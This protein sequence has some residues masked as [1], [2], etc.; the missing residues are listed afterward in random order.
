[1]FVCCLG[2]MAGLYFAVLATRRD[3]S[4]NG[5]RVL[6]FFGNGGLL[7]LCLLAGGLFALN[8]TEEAQNKARN[9]EQNRIEGSRREHDRKNVRLRLTYEPGQD[10]L[11]LTH[12]TWRDEFDDYRKVGS[13]GT[14]HIGTFPAG[15]ELNV[16][17][18]EPR[19]FELTM[20]FD[21]G[22]VNLRLE[23]DNIAEAAAWSDGKEVAFPMALGAGKHR[24]VIKGR[25][26]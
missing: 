19:R 1:M 9:E 23:A 18:P 17:W 11:K 2:L 26:P 8:A 13:D 3:A 10:W 4:S 6:C 16:A 25:C 24:I 22:D 5:L 7:G 14:M 15:L 12:V 20:V 21:S